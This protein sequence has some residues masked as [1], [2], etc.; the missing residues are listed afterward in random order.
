[1]KERIIHQGFASV[2]ARLLQSSHR[3][4]IARLEPLLENEKFTTDCRHDRTYYNC[5]APSFPGTSWDRFFDGA[6]RIYEGACIPLFVDVAITGKCHCKCWHC[7]RAGY[8]QGVDFAL[9]ELVSLFNE[10]KAAG[11]VVIGITGGEPMMRQD[12]S[13]VLQAI[14]DGVEGLFYSTGHRFT[15]QFVER[16]TET[17]VT[18]C[19]I[20]LDHYD[21]DKVNAKRG[22]RRAF[23]DAMN[24][25]R[26]LEDANLFTGITLCATEEFGVADEFKRYMEF[27]T[28]L[29]VDE[30]R[31]VL[32]IPQGNLR[33]RTSSVYTLT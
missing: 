2:E 24:A 32:P 3:D 23:D 14:P 12:I 8:E 9:D 28:K 7:F 19:L 21:A 1:M 11:T 15:R 5:L 27:A 25:I 4:A 29:G 31:I 33:G 13:S 26:L 17:N 30:I 10:L 18:R 22:H 6:L 16:L 20:S